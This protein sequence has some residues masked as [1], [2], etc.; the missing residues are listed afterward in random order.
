MYRVMGRL[1]SDPTGPNRSI[2]VEQQ[3]GGLTLGGDD[4]ALRDLRRTAEGDRIVYAT[5]VGPSWTMTDAMRDPLGVQF[6]I[7]DTM[8]P[9]SIRVD[10][11]AP[12]VM[13]SGPPDAVF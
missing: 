3:P 7:F 2:I 5:P 1:R 13:E 10:G 8:V 6:V 11:D 12:V 9:G 4:D